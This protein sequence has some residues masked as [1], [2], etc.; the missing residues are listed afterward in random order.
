MTPT[1]ILK[2]DARVMIQIR[3][4]KLM[5]LRMGGQSEDPIIDINIV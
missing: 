4:G 3:G 1:D 5:E 2:F